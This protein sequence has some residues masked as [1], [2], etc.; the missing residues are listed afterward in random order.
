MNLEEFKKDFVENIRNDSFA[1]RNTPN[2]IFLENMIRRLE[3]ISILFNTTSLSFYKTTKQS[4]TLKFDAFSID[5]VDKTLILIANEYVDEVNPKIF[6]KESIETTAKYM[7]NF[8]KEVLKGTIT[9]F[10]DPS[11]VELLNFA[12]DLKRRLE[13]DY[14]KTDQDDSLDKVKFVILTNRKLTN[15]QLKINEN[16]LGDR[17]IEIDV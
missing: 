5:E 15:R 9:Q 4:K 10:I 17:E 8:L 13:I 6:N 12:K 3:E 11:M 1:F 14:V 7:S 16:E 2:N